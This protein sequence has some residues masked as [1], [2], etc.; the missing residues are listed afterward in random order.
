MTPMT[1]QHR[2]VLIAAMERIL[3]ADPGHGATDAN[4]I[5]YAEWLM[6]Q[7][8]FRPHL[9]CWMAGLTLLDQVA[10]GMWGKSFPLCRAEE[11]DAAIARLQE[12]PH[13]SVQ[14]FLVMLI[15]ITLGGFLCPPRYGGNW[16]LAGWSYVGFDPHPQTTGAALGRCPERCEGVPEKAVEY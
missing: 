9:R 15:R 1:E 5:G 14:K 11:Q 12:T 7:H 4:A 8:A 10:Q 2:L 3:P 13:F 16:N 6:Q